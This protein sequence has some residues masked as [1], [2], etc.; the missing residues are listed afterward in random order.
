MKVLH[1]LKSNKYSGAENVVLTIMDA[2]SDD[3]EMVYASPDGP[4]RQVVENRNH[5]FYA[6][7]EPTIREVKKAIHE[8]NPDVIHAHDFSMSSI[9]AWASNGI[10]VI[11]HLHNNP[12]WLKKLCPRSIIY[13]FS[14]LHIKQIISVSKSIEEE[15]IFR[16]FMKKKNTIVGNVVDRNNVMLKAKEYNITKQADLVFLGRMSE[17]KNPLGF[18]EIIYELKKSIPNVNAYM[19]G[20]GEL[21]PQVKEYIKTHE[22]K[23]AIDL[24]GF[25]SNP[26]PYL[27]KSKIMVVPSI[28]EGF[29]LAAVEGMCLGKTVVCSGVGGLADIVNY[30]CGAICNSIEDFCQS[31]KNQ[32]IDEDKYR[33]LSQNAIEQSKK[34]TD[35]DRYK[36]KIISIYN[37][38]LEIEEK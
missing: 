13:A 37:K 8:L 24:I 20:D 15:Y 16:N 29:G 38:A 21:M 26:Y 31:I 12:L 6:L 27:F 7:A 23:N 32:L 34:F 4:I 22:L 11:S 25:K 3:I 17:P 18:C 36:K 28:W 10:P 30:E 2:C 1:L 19:I 9:A 35:I 14:M 33:E 5:M